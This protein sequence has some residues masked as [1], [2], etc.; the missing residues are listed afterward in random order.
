M[1]SWTS[2]S[3]MPI[4]IPFLG[5]CKRELSRELTQMDA[6]QLRNLTSTLLAE[7]AERD[8]QIS[9]Q[10][11]KVSAQTARIASHARAASLSSM[12][13]G[14]RLLRQQRSKPAAEALRQWLT[15][16][17]GQVPDGS[18]TRK[19]IDYSLG[20]WAGLTRYLD[21]DVVERLLTQPAS[22]VGELLPHRWALVQ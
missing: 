12:P 4:R 1:R 20:R 6:D 13:I 11:A 18:A 3:F 16:Q 22:R 2:V 5:S 17:R 10:N 8:A 7:L 14:R 19:A 15:R 9:Q 21:D